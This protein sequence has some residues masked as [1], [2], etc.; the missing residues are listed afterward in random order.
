[1]KVSIMLIVFSAILISGCA[2]QPPSADEIKV[3][4]SE[5]LYNKDLRTMSSDRTIPVTITRDA[6]FLGSLATV[7]LKIDGEYVV[8]LNTREEITIYLEPGGYVFELV[9]ALC[10]DSQYCVFPTDVTIKP[11]F[12]NNFRI[13]FNNSNGLILARASTAGS[14]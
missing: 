14:I 12:K 6:G 4:P 2:T 3:A 13:L 9:N 5:R 7:F 11:G 10:P 8:W 1:M